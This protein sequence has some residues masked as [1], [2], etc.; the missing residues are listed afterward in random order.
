[1]FNVSVDDFAD[2]SLI[3]IEAG[4]KLAVVSVEKPFAANEIVPVNPPC[5]VAVT[6]YVVEPPGLTVR[7][8][9]AI[10]SEKS[11]VGVVSAIFAINMS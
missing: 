2:E 9:G 11:A 6:V 7:V 4:V 1:M 3:T 5:G 10:E 8:A